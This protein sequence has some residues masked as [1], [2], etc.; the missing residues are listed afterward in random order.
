MRER[1]KSRIIKTISEFNSADEDEDVMT[2]HLDANLTTHSRDVYVPDRELPGTWSWSLRYRKFR[3]REPGATERQLGADGI[4]ELSVDGPYNSQVK[5][6][7]FQSKME[8]SHGSREL[9]EQC[10]KLSNWREAAAV[11]SYGPDRFAGISLDA[12][13]GAK[14]NLVEA[15]GVDLAEFLADLFVACTIG[16]TELRYH[17]DKKMLSWRDS[18]RTRVAARFAVKHRIKINVKRPSSLWS[19]LQGVN[20]ISAD[21]I[22]KHRMAISERDM[23][24]VDWGATYAQQKAAQKAITRVY[25]PDMWSGWPDQIRATMEART[26]EV[27][28]IKIKKDR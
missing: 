27:Q 1:F 8:K 6:M 12:V 28:G 7:L 23:L 26:K 21:E 17:T 25:H 24:G 9:V 4:I 13:L 14:G 5:S 16:D 2:G 15:K 20:E 11:F 3:G 10:S 22:N 19:D 18:Q